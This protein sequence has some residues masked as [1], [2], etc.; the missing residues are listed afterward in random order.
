MIK[1]YFI[2]IALL[3]AFCTSAVAENTIRSYSDPK[4]IIQQDPSNPNF[5][6]ELPSNRTTGYAWI[7]ES[8]DD[9]IVTVKNHQYLPPQANRPGAGG[10]EQWQFEFTNRSISFPQISKIKLIYAR[11]WNLEIG[12][13]IEFFVVTKQ[14]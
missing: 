2:T 5:I 3:V 11:P 1:Q 10:V 14:L 6:I 7:L 9:K 4:K 12:K 13:K 8:Y